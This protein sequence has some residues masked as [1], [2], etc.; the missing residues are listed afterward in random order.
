VG[1]RKKKSDAGEPLG[2]IGDCT[3]T[4]AELLTAITF[5]ESSIALR[6]AAAA[7][8]AEQWEEIL[9]EARARKTEAETAL[10]N[11]YYAHKAE[12][13]RNGAK[14]LQL[15]NGVMGR[16]TNPP[17][18]KKLRGW[19]WERVKQEVWVR[20]GG[21]YFHRQDDPPLDKDRLKELAAEEL[22]KLGMK[23]ESSETFYAEPSR[24]DGK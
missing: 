9:E 12:I 22:E 10:R 23:L 5:I 24:I 21:T 17:A 6:D 19:S 2:S 18:L 16:R 13:E 7:V 1:R 4:M 8:V 14:H 11:Y 15:D 20:L 3:R